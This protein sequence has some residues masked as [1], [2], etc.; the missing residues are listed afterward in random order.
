MATDVKLR[1]AAWDESTVHELADGQRIARATVRL[2]E[3][4]DALTGTFTSDLHYRADGTS[5]F[6]TLMH[7]TGSIDGHAGEVVLTGD[8]TFDGTTASVRFEV[9][10]GS[11]TGELAGVGGTAVST[12]TKGDYPF[13]PM[14]FEL[15]TAG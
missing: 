8:G 3:P 4:G 7:L 15:T 1:I 12:S 5:T 9:A 13:M 14:R 2:G 10:A 6:V 11:G